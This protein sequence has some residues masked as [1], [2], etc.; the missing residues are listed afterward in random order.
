LR[1]WCYHGKFSCSAI[2]DAASPAWNYSATHATG[3]P[4]GHMV[5]PLNVFNG[6]YTQTNIGNQT[7]NNNNNN[8]TTNNNYNTTCQYSHAENFFAPGGAVVYAMNSC[9]D[10]SL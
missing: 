2:L 9:C 1:R 8:R 3:P 10:A 6:N 4:H 5:Q 7:T